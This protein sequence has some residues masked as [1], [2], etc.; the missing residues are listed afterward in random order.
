MPRHFLEKAMWSSS[1]KKKT[2]IILCLGILFSVLVAPCSRGIAEDE[3][4]LPSDWTPVEQDIWR[5]I[6]SGQMAQLLQP[7]QEESVER[8]TWTDDQKVSAKFLKI[9]LTD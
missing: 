1:I 2:R 6:V 5:T 8:Q 4:P 9:I 7:P 3:Q